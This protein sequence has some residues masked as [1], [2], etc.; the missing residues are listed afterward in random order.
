MA[1]EAGAGRRGDLDL[2]SEPRLAMFKRDLEA[3]AASGGVAVSD[4]HIQ[5]DT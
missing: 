1:A 4:V 2:G 3:D 5:F